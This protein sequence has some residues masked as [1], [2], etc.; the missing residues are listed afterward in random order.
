MGFV[1]LDTLRKMGMVSTFLAGTVAEVTQWRCSD[2]GRDRNSH[3]YDDR[4]NEERR[5]CNSRLERWQDV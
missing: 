5:K 2:H 3:D 1:E 4:S